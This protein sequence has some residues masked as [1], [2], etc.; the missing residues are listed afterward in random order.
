MMWAL[1]LDQSM[2]GTKL[3][4]MVSKDVS[5]ICPLK[6]CHHKVALHQGMDPHE[7]HLGVCQEVCKGV[8]L[9]FR[10]NMYLQGQQKVL[11]NG[12][13]EVFYRVDQDVHSKVHWGVHHDVHLKVCF[14]HPKFLEKLKCE[15]ENGNNIKKSQG[16]FLS[17]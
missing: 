4:P 15:Y 9:E 7:V 14:T 8:H 5:S 6:G 17:L 10:Q 12:H 3:V 13:L 2:L 11:H 1:G 16:T